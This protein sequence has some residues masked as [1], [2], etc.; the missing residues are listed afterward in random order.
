MI[1]QKPSTRLNPKNVRKINASLMAICCVVFAKWL[2]DAYSIN[3]SGIL[4]QGHLT[5]KYMGELEHQRTWNAVYSYLTKSGR[6]YSG[7]GFIS[8]SLYERI[9]PGDPITIRYVPAMPAVSAPWEGSNKRRR[10]AIT[11]FLLAGLWA[12]WRYWRDPMASRPTSQ[13]NKVDFEIPNVIR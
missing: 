10:L 4:A 2:F 5:R 8:K 11:A 6:T 1:N 12:T 3:R 7:E 9:L 13:K